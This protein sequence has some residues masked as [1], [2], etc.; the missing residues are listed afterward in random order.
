M[1][2]APTPQELEHAVED[3]S[4]SFAVVR[5]LPTVTLPRDGELEVPPLEYASIA[6]SPEPV[7]VI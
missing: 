2:D 3:D 4:R 6:A 7:R 1:R 5:P